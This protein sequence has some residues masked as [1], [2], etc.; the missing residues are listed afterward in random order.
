MSFS[1]ISCAG[2]KSTQPPEKKQAPGSGEQEMVFGGEYAKLSPQQQKIIDDWFIH[3]NQATG[4]TFEPEPSY[5]EIPISSRTTFEAVTHALQTT[6]LTDK[7]GNSLG[8]ALDIISVLETVRGKIPGAGGD[9]QFRIYVIVKPDAYDVLQQSR[10]FKRKGDN[11]IYHKGYPINFR[12]DGKEP[13]M[14][15]SMS[16]D[17]R[18]ADIDV[19]YRSSKFPM[20]LFNGHLTSSNSDI[21]AGKNYDRHTNKWS[22]FANWWRNLFGL[23]TSSETTELQEIDDTDIPLVPKVSSK[24]KIEE[25]VYDFLNTWLV[26]QKPIFSAA[27]FS[28]ESYH[29]LEYLK[30]SE[31]GDEDTLITK[32][33]ARYRLLAE[34]ENVNRILGKHSNLDGLISG[35]QPK[36]PT[37]RTISH[38]YSDQFSVAEVPEDVGRAFLCSN[39]DADWLEKVRTPGTEKYGKYF[40]I[41]FRIFEAPDDPGEVVY[42][43]WTK[44]DKY[45]KIVSFE[46]D[47]PEEGDV[48]PD[49]NPDRFDI[50][51][52]PEIYTVGDPEQIHANTAFLKSWLGD[53]DFD[54]AFEYF[55]SECYDCVLLY[56]EKS[57]KM[58][59]QKLGQ[60]LKER[61]RNTKKFIERVE[62]LEDVIEGVDVDHP[63]IKNVSH[64]HENYFSILS[65]P[66]YYGEQVDCKTEPADDYFPADDVP[67]VYG[68]YYI[69]ALMM[70]VPGMDRGVL[71]LLW[72]KRDGNWK[73]TAYRVISP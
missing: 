73:I 35:V 40:G 66:D 68:N 63:D 56:M 23:R 26:E 13:T 34:M 36:N 5:N 67:R 47:P 37:V 64:A 43:L 71:Y 48:V 4:N 38:P 45:W 72:A 10:E 9:L 62:R 53:Q 42:L 25:A 8:S 17:K 51:E 7:E 24:E 50:E 49:V 60:T 59:R 21:R 69:T 20:A 61:F 1:L 70:A 12:Q 30:E 11:T 44:E 31:T 57:D 27:Y 3:F 14:Q 6:K 2:Q 16:R 33:F 32:S 58:S 22:G 29:C 19:D 18:H 55:A 41:G 65:I 39:R 28:P 54:A 15:V 46:V 52:I